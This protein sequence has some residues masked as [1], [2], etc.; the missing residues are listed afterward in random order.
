MSIAYRNRIY[1]KYSSAFKDEGKVFNKANAERWGRSYDYYLRG[2]LPQTKDSSIL[3]VGCGSGGL[4]YFF[5]QRGFL[6]ITGVDTS[7]EQCSLARQTGAQ[8]LQADG[9]NFLVE[10]PNEFD[11]ITAFDIVEHLE[12]DEV[13]RF[14]DGCI[15]ALKPRGKLIL[16]TPNA[17]SPF[18]SSVRYGDFTHEVCFNPAI[19]SRLLRMCGFH[20][21]EAREQSPVPVGYSM[22]ST[23]R[24]LVWQAF[25]AGIGTWNL[26]ETGSYGDAVFSRVFLISARK[27]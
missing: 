5:A 1:E 27:P 9:L 7:P 21:T 23:V 2:W 12:K 15:R 10:H 6:R 22:I 25:R 19:L 11:L 4:L 18:C 16:Q 14:L 8:V 24:F 3:D 13:L 20:M 26:V 17:A